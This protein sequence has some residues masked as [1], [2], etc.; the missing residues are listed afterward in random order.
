MNSKANQQ[1]TFHNKMVG[2]VREALDVKGGKIKTLNKGEKA[3]KV[4]DFMLDGHYIKVK[5]VH[6][7]QTH[8]LFE[9]YNEGNQSWFLRTRAR[10]V[11]YVI[12]E[13]SKA[14]MINILGV[15]DYISNPHNAV[16]LYETEFGTKAYML[17]IE[18]LQEQSLITDV[19]HL[20]LKND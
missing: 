5:A 2:K 11:A 6:K 8:C 7:S 16:I 14:Y 9:I 20:E 4:A 1:W 17:S 19:L 13:S 3:I 18:T 10:Y 15:K 12:Q